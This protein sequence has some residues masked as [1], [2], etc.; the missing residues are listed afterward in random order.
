MTS[1]REKVL[2]VHPGG[3][4]THGG[5]GPKPEWKERGLQTEEE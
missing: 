2:W 3:V 4:S 1:G 5:S